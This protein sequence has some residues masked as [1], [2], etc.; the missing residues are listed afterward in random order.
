[1]NMLL[2]PFVYRLLLFFATDLTLLFYSPRNF[3]I[4]ARTSQKHDQGFGNQPRSL[5][6]HLM[7]I[8]AKVLYVNSI[9]LSHLIMLNMIQ[10]QLFFLALH[11]LLPVWFR[12]LSTFILLFIFINYKFQ[13]FKFINFSHKF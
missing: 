5:F 1:M 6:L 12:L 3:H 9:G 7:K 2:H 11:L 13:L 10:L 4:Y 8:T